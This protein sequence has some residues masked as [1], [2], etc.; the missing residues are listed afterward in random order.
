MRESASLLFPFQ[1]DN[2]NEC[3]GR[4]H[5]VEDTVLSAIRSF[6]ITRKGSRC[7]S[8]LGSFL[9]ELLLQGVPVSKLPN[10]SDELKK[11]LENQFAGV[12]F[13]EVTL[14]QDLS[15]E[16]AT[17]KVHI[18]LSIPASSGIVAFELSLPSIFT[19]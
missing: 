8:N 16:V 19:N 10:L 11:E 3:L 6:L 13:L 5:T 12:S 15:D 4:A 1:Y 7:G 18:K 14:T 17:L 9:P 2:E